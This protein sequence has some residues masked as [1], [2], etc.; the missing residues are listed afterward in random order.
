MLECDTQLP[1]SLLTCK[2]KSNHSA[3]L[4]ATWKLWFLK[5]VVYFHSVNIFRILEY[6]LKKS[7]KKYHSIEY[8]DI[9]LFLL[10]LFN[11]SKHF[12]SSPL[13][14]SYLSMATTKG[15]MASLGSRSSCYDFYVV[16]YFLTLKSYLF[17]ELLVFIIYW[18]R[19]FATA[20]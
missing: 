20:I 19:Q 12:Q 15:F 14:P 11:S 6:K 17:P 9:L 2:V 7:L 8:I 5:K 4:L 1:P 10:R 16:P 18:Y 13:I 3:A